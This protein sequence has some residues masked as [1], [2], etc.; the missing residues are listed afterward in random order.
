MIDIQDLRQLKNLLE[1][2]D[3]LEELEKLEKEVE[4]LNKEKE[5]LLDYKRR[6]LAIVS[7]IDWD[8]VTSLC[9]EPKTTKAEET[10]TL[11][12]KVIETN[13]RTYGECIRAE[14]K[15]RRLTLQQTA[16]QC[17][18]AL[19]T[20]WEIENDIHKNNENS[21]LKLEERLGI[22]II[23]KNG[24][25]NNNNNRNIKIIK[26]G[27]RTYGEIY[28]GER[29]LQKL[30]LKQVGDKGHISAS[31]VS[32]V[33]TNKRKN[34]RKSREKVEYALNIKVEE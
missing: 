32:D 1:K 31:T 33:E 9:N 34:N 25:N 12:V 3:K 28:R 27:N 17:N 23:H 18:L 30:S 2:L 6:Y 4:D 29:L 10:P 16:K 5:E 24:Q 14:R 22:K 20:V 19:R 7:I 13:G 15:L 11:N 21:K 26:K 8:G